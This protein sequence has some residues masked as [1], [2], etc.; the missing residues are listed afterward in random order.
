M[1]L[2]SLWILIMLYTWIA[3]DRE[4]MDTYTIKAMGPILW[5]IEFK[6]TF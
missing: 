5:D 6:S 3:L 2:V 4:D 1:F